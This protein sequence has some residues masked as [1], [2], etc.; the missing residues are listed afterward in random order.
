MVLWLGIRLAAGFVTGPLPGPP[1]PYVSV[2]AGIWV[3]ALTALR[4]AGM[5]VGEAARLTGISDQL[6]QKPPGLSGGELRRAEVALALVREPGCLLADD[7]F[8]GIA[9]VDTDAIGAAIR[10]LA[11]RGAAVV[12][13]GHE[14]PTLLAIADRVIW[15]AHGTTYHLGTAAEA[16]GD[17]RFEREYLGES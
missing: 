16:R 10:H 11:S 7:P 13:T 15:C 17:W 4:F 8:R 9:P 14:V 1:F 2:G 6:D 5:P 3:V 12:C